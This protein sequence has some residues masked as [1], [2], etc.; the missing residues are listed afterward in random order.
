MPHQY[1]LNPLRSISFAQFRSGLNW[2]GVMVLVAGLGSAVLVWRAQD[3]IDRESEAAQSADAS[4]PLS[5]LDSRK[6]VRDVEMYYGKV[7]VLEEE[8]GELLHG[9]PLAKIIGVVSILTATGLFLVA[10]RLGE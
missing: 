4:A 10:A 6:Q 5:S 9:K 3:R 2:L 7:G 8:A 1:N